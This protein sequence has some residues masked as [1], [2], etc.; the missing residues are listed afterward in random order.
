M[1]IQERY[2]AS[3]GDN[4]DAQATFNA[5]TS[6]A[7][8]CSLTVALK[9]AVA[10]DRVHIAQ[11]K[12]NGTA[13][14][15][16]S[17]G[18]T[19]DTPTNSGTATSPVIFHG[20]KLD[21][22]LIVP[23]RTNGNG[24]L[25]TTDYPVLTWS[26]GGL[27]TKAFTVFRCLN[28]TSEKNGATVADTANTHISSCVIN[29]FG[30]GASARALSLA[31]AG[32]GINNDIS[33]TSASGGAAALFISFGRV[34]FNRITCS[35]G[36]TCP[37]VVASSTSA[38]PIIQNNLIYGGAGVGIS[39]TLTTGYETIVGNTIVDN[40]GSGIY[41][42]AGNLALNT[43]I[44]NQ[45]TDNGG[46]G[47]EAAEAA[48]AIY[49]TNN[50]ITRNTSGDTNGAA[51]WLAATGF[52]NVTAAQAGATS[53]I[54]RLAEYMSPGSPNYDY[55]LR[56]ESLGRGAGLWGKDIGALF[57]NAYYESLHIGGGYIHIGI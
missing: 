46:Y 30:T 40:A 25:V 51:D 8:A 27:T 7:A 4:T 19:S 15:Y 2:V 49:W 1:A 31:N 35:G 24:P 11:G 55:R 47:I 38:N 16:A 39:S 28:L 54:Q 56:P 6:L 52:G 48:C 36:N 21:G 10:G 13:G 29:N 42:A 43:V 12:C 5:A 26:T 17:R 20:A 23:S 44:N 33:L 57:I 41:F 3:D 32:T 45:I 50:R 9:Y 34:F 18:G 53:A 22:T 14:A 37:V